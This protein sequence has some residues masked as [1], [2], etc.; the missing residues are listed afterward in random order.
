MTKRFL[1][2]CCL[3]AAVMVGG[4]QAQAGNPGEPVAAFTIVGPPIVELEGLFEISVIANDAN[5]SPT[6]PPS[7]ATITLSAYVAGSGEPVL[8]TPSSFTALGSGI[9][10]VIVSISE[11]AS[12]TRV[13]IQATGYGVFDPSGPNAPDIMVVNSSEFGTEA[14]RFEISV[15]C[16]ANP[17]EAF[18]IYI[19][20]VEATGPEG[21]ETHEATGYV[22]DLTLLSEY[23]AITPTSVSINVQAGASHMVMVTLDS[24]R[25]DNMIHVAWPQAPPE[26]AVTFKIRDTSQINSNSVELQ[27][28]SDVAGND[29]SLSLLGITTE[30][31]F[32]SQIWPIQEGNEFDGGW[33]MVSFIPGSDPQDDDTGIYMY[34]QL[35]PLS[36]S[37]GDLPGDSIYWGQFGVVTGPG[38]WEA[39]SG[40]FP[41]DFAG[42]YYRRRIFAAD[43]AAGTSKT[44]HTFTYDSAMFD[45]ILTI[46]E[47]DGQ[48][49]T[50]D[51]EPISNFGVDEVTW[52]AM[53]WTVPSASTGD[54]VYHMQATFEVS[55]PEQSPQETETVKLLITLAP[56]SRPNPGGIAFMPDSLWNEDYIV[57]QATEFLNVTGE[58][59]PPGLD[60]SFWTRIVVLSAPGDGGNDVGWSKHINT[61]GQ[62]IAP[63]QLHVEN[64][65]GGPGDVVSVEVSIDL[66][67]GEDAAGVQFDIEAGTGAEFQGA[68]NHQPNFQ[69]STSNPAAGV[70]R[71]LMVSLNGATTGGDE[72]GHHVLMQL[73][74]E[75][76]DQLN[77]G[78]QIALDVSASIISDPESNSLPH[79]VW[80]AFIQI[81]ERGDLSGNDGIVDVT[82][83]TALIG[84]ILEPDETPDPETFAFFQ[85]DI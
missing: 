82:D 42:G 76:A 29:N 55:D 66:E 50:G 49:D 1:F 58:A 46:V 13:E 17:N 22:G 45:Q 77:Y 30:S 53:I 25:S 59:L 68:I 40:A 52:D 74:Y 44:S 71:V 35:V 67:Q 2:S 5:W 51:Q 39:T 14:N 79:D 47:A 75:L 19:T 10:Q 72:S 36:V 28:F 84:L 48:L 26:T 12:G 34:T 41:P 11:V 21:S 62:H 23:G 6:V 15:P 16:T 85:A 65:A 43:G 60:G 31:E 80:N 4:H 56:S 33:N 3:L 38:G 32:Q 61:T 37:F 9:D 64:T 70:T 54:T 27:L 73:I 81:G 18:P 24:V 57:N 69:I 78:D 8:I 83:L 7:A 20:P 63:N